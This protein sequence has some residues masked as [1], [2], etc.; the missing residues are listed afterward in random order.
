MRTLTATMTL[1]SPDAVEQSAAVR[2]R[3]ADYFELTKP[4]IA[5]M[6]LFTVAVGFFLGAAP[7]PSLQMLLHTL[8]GTALV[9]AGGSALNHWLERRADARMNRT[10]NR[11]LPSGRMNSA[12]VFAFGATL[13]ILGVAYLAFAIP[14]HPSAAIAAAATAFLYVAVYTPMKRLTA[15]NTVVGAIPGAL[16][17][18]IGW[19]AAHGTLT[20]DALALFLILFVWQLPHFFSIAFMHRHDYARGGMKMLP[21]VERTDGY[22]T[23]VAT[24][25]TCVLLIAVGTTPYLIGSAREIFLIGSFALGIWFLT[26]AIRFGRN[27][28]ERTARQVL[29][30]SLIYLM[31]VMALLIIDWLLPRYIG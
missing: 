21:C 20:A 5:F 4:R 19:C 3:M 17:P 8:I 12:D 23:G 13:A 6:A 14:H 25:A 24:I 26:R 9:A 1:P 27:R 29:R 10:S 11:P 22:W 28:T 15:W 7:S 2:S 30:G 18:V 31:G 16:P